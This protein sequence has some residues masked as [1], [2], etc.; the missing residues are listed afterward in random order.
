M[1]GKRTT[2][3]IQLTDIQKETL[4][5]WKRSTTIMSC[6]CKRAQIILLFSEKALIKDISAKLCIKRDKVTKWGLRFL[7]MGIEG[8]YDK[9]GRGRKPVF[10]P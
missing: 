5:S 8:L 7:S 10:S 1:S 6:L 2:I 3:D 4:L 9:P